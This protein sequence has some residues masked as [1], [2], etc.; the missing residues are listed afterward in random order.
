MT[1]KTRKWKDIYSNLGALTQEG[2]DKI[3]LKVKIIG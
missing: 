1:V 3:E 2:R